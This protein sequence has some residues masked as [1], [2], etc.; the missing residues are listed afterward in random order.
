[1]TARSIRM[2]QRGFTLV[3][4]IM[5]M[6]IIGILGGMVMVFIQKPV[7]AYT[8]NA[9]RAEL[10]DVADLALRR[11]ARDLRLALPNSIRINPAGDSIEFLITRTGGRYLAAE[12]AADP[13]LP[14]LDFVDPNNRA[15]TVVGAL[16]GASQLTPGA[17]YLVVN[18]LG[19]GFAPADAY[20]LQSAQR[21]IALVTGVVPALNQIVLKDNPF[22]AQNPPLASPG[23][24]FQIVSGAVT[25]YCGLEADNVT[26]LLTRQSGYGI[27]AAQTANP[28]PAG[29][30]TGKRSLLAGRVKS[31]QF[32]YQTLNQRSG[33][34]V[35]TL[36]LQ[37]R[38]STDAVIRLV[39]QIHVENT[40]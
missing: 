38:N 17:D 40:P 29:A 34:V 23:S 4:S 33:L 16:P 21:N 9:A 30:A 5:V 18:N 28:V 26:R 11:M 10:T 2:R 3:E 31:C 13:A 37:P 14:V 36:E 7:Q 19:P 25:Y 20:Q 32:D 27:A 39:H 8:D 12:D 15:L 35:I 1:M 6:V 24:R 22:A